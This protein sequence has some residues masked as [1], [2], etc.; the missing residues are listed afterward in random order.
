VKTVTEQEFKNRGQQRMKAAVEKIPAAK[1]MMQ[2]VLPRCL[3]QGCSL[4]KPYISIR[5]CFT[6]NPRESVFKKMSF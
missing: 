6:G 2:Q 3:R 4:N 5:L 1:P